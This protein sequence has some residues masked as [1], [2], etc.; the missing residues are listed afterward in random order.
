MLIGSFVSVNAYTAEKAASNI[1]LR[2]KYTELTKQL[3]SNQFKR[4]LYLNSMESSHD[5]KGEIYAVV[6]YPF[7]TVNQ[8]LNN[9]AH[10][11]DLLILHINIKYCNA[12]ENKNGTTLSVNLGKKNEQPLADTYRVDFNYRE[13]ITTPDYFALELNAE[14]GP[15]N[16]RDYRIWV[17]ATPIKGGRTFLHFTYAYAFGLAGRLAM[18]GYLSTVG[19]DK[20][21]FTVT[22]KLPDGSPNYIKGVRGVVERNTM[23]YYLA[24]DAYL[25]E[26]N[27]PSN[28]QLEQRLQSWYR[29][30]EE[31]PRQ[32]HEVELNEYM[33]MK[34]DEYKR[35]Q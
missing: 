10:W 11:C 18:Q 13:I 35:Q 34:R 33:A 19:S 30:T 2:A 7:A 21:G 4:A 24:I 12:D 15:L 29:S 32:L 9:P 16:T 28:Q 8:A 3:N 17:E 14:N 1:P 26:L 31:Y 20:V 27:T 23:R 25:A 22:G 6:D 5:L